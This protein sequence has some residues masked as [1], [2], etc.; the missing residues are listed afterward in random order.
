MISPL[1]H[2]S[3]IPPKII[4]AFFLQP[5]TFYMSLQLHILLFYILFGNLLF[6]DC[7]ST[8][9]ISISAWI[10]RFPTIQVPHLFPKLNREVSIPFPSPPHRPGVEVLPQPLPPSHSSSSAV[11]SSL[12]PPIP[13]IKPEPQPPPMCPSR[14]K[15]PHASPTHHTPS[16]GQ[17]NHFQPSP[18]PTIAITSLKF[19]PNRRAIVL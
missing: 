2:E 5:F 18:S 16:F 6:F 12:P 9:L 14:R 4:S 3:V 13:V 15:A 19:P 17:N 10:M 7:I 8:S 1:K 11:P